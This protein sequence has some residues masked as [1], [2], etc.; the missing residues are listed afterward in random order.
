MID[1]GVMAEKVQNKPFFSQPRH[2]YNIKERNCPP[3]FL[4]SGGGCSMFSGGVVE[5]EGWMQTTS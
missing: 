4:V 2:T 1:L 5:R 3:T